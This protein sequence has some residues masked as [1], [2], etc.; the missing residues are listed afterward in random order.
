MRRCPGQGAQIMVMP[1]KKFEYDR[2][3]HPSGGFQKLA[4]FCTAGGECMIDQLPTDQTGILKN[5]GPI[6]WKRKKRQRKNRPLI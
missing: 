4:Y 1:M 3:K 5:R 6:E 2:T